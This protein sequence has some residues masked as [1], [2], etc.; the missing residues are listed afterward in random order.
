MTPDDFRRLAL[1]MHG[2]IEGAHMRHPDF[3]ANGRIFATLHA[4]EL[5]G[6]VKLTSEE[7]EAFL[8]AHAKVFVPASGAWGRQG[9]TNVRLDA[10]DEATARGA[11][12]LAWQNVVDKPSGRRS[13][14]PD[15]RLLVRPSKRLR[16]PPGS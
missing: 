7:Q 1:S 9:W 12:I 15:D 8:T 2:A 5:W 3:R 13:S 4:D 14:K 11:M 10:A 16:R 6:T